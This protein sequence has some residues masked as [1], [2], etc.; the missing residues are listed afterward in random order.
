MRIPKIGMINIDN[1]FKTLQAR[2]RFLPNRMISNCPS[3]PVPGCNA[4][5]SM[6]QWP[7]SLAM[8]IPRT[9]SQ[10]C[11]IE[12]PRKKLAIC[13]RTFKTWSA[14]DGDPPKIFLRERYSGCQAYKRVRIKSTIERIRVTH[15]RILWARMRLVQG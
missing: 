5:L 7:F 12:T 9:M 11:P 15:G 4:R 2:A 14:C 1:N 13:D 8:S 10:H 3:K 6:K